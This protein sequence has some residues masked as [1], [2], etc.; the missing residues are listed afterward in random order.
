MDSNQI[1]N[2]YCSRLKTEGIIK[3]LL[4]GLT[5]GL[6]VAA[7]LTFI[8]WLVDF[9]YFWIA[10]IIGVAI[11]GAATPMFYHWMFR[12]TAKSMAHRVDGLGLEERIVTMNELQGDNSYIAQR[13]RE[14]AK[15]ALVSLSKAAT[16]AGGKVAGMAAKGATK[17][18]MRIP[19]K[20][21]A[22]VASVAMSY[23][24]I[25]TVGILSYNG[26]IPK[27]KAIAEQIV[28]KEI[29]YHTVSYITYGDGFIEGDSD[30]VIAD[31]E[32]TEIVM[33][34]AEDG[35][36]FYGWI[37]AQYL[38]MLGLLQMFGMLDDYI[39]S[40]EPVRLDE[41]ITADLEMCALF[42]EMSDNK[43]DPS[44]GDGDGEPGQ[45]GD[46]EPGDGDGNGAGDPGEPGNGSGQPG[47]GPGQP[48]P[49]QP[50]GEGN[51]DPGQPS[52][53][54]GAG[55]GQSKQDDTWMDGD[56]PVKDYYQQIWEEAM[57]MIAEGKEL[58]ADVREIIE[59]YF[60]GLKP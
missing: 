9:E 14:D 23:S 31:G 24:A 8:F 13:Q 20:I 43:G 4:C 60:G 35:W 54:D 18:A 27:A 45:P 57:Q 1:Y 49:G 48:G 32:S 59:G 34:V 3:A 25:Q 38:D 5:I 53:G 46:G 19:T 58:P 51:G 10:P 56:T 40:N 15:A 42:V 16:T 17:L 29:E 55:S 12:P 11:A 39:E 33:A 50:G 37:D 36:Y 30:Q 41:N 6:F 52:Y 2:K 7:V 44:D 26:T 22:A 28:D 21:I 47:D